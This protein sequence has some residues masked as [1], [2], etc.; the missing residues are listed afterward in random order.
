MQSYGAAFSNGDCTPMAPCCNT[1]RGTAPM[2]ALS[3]PG[4]ALCLTA[5]RLL[6]IAGTIAFILEHKARKPDTTFD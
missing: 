4:V 2:V 6:T 1:V 3:R 5:T